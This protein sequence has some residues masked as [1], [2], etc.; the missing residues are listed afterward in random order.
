MRIVWKL[1][2][3]AALLVAAVMGAGMAWA[4]EPPEPVVGAVAEVL[5][6]DLHEQTVLIPVTVKDLYGRTETR[7]I[8]VTIYRPTGPG[9][10]PLLVFNHG[11][12]VAAKRATQG[13]NRPEHLARY[14]VAKGFVVL[15]PTRV[16]Y[17]DTHGD[18]DPEYSGNCNATQIEPAAVAATDQVF[19]TR[20]FARTLPYVDADRWIVAGQS[21]GGLTAVA[22][23]G[24]N[25]PGLLGGINFAGG[26]GGNPDTQPENPCS[27]N[28]LVRYWGTLGKSAAVPMLWLYWENDKYWG[29]DIPRRWFKA[30]AEAGAKA[31]MTTFAP[32]GLDGH[33]GSSIDMDHWLPVVDDFLAQLGFTQPAIVK[34]P[35][36]SGFADV[37]DAS[38]V[39]V[40]AKNQSGAYA[41]FL[42]AKLPRAFAVGNKGGWGYAT[43]D[44]VTGRALGY[45]QRSGQI[46]KLY[47]VDD[48][49]VWTAD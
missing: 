20:A 10:F 3:T 11:R 42:Q 39:P 27:P 9:P 1:N 30:W 40:S 15:A 37:T 4:Q 34:R 8:P 26:S 2:P 44:Y 35:P 24:R 22:T 16:G 41:K 47:A 17:A 18:F 12:A 19:A 36:A 45:C 46:C 13:R 28:T 49:V 5:A 43:G 21:M 23:V 6:K 25:P 38:K 14:F 32:A 7:S 33:S 48:Q 29:P 31:N